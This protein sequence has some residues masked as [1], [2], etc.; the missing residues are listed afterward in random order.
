MSTSSNRSSTKR[1][2]VMSSIFEAIG[3][4]P[5]VRLN[6]IPKEEGVECEILA[7]C[8]FMNPGGSIKDRIS[9]EMINVAEAEGL[10]TPG[11]TIVEA[12]SGNTGIGLAL[13]SAVKGYKTIITIPDRMSNEKVSTLK[14]LGS[15]VIRTPSEAKTFDEASYYMLAKRLQKETPNAHILDQYGNP[16]NPSVHERTTGQEIFDQTEGNLDFVFAGAGTGGTITGVARRLK[17]L[18]PHIKVVGVDPMGSTLALPE[19]LNLPKKGLQ[20]E[21][22]GKDYVPKNLDRSLI[23]AWVKTDDPD[24]LRL[25]RALIAKEG[26]LC[27]SS[28]GAALEGCLKF[29]KENNLHTDPSIRCVIILP[30]SIRNYLSKFCSDEYMVK[31]GFM[32][33]SVLSSEDH[34]LHGKTIGDL[35]LQPISFFDDRLPVTECKKLFAKGEVAV[36]LTT[37]GKL[38]GIITRDSIMNWLTKKTLNFSA[39]ANAI[40]KEAIVV[41]YETDLSSIDSLLR[42]DDAVYVQRKD[43]D[44]KLLAIYAVTKSDLIKLLAQDV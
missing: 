10:L 31:K 16:A 12:S 25:A 37:E 14:S 32:Q 6:R 38:R 28:S 22:I 29:L 2:G 1:D 42:C 17:S 15:A 9:L 20:V 41:D 33:A 4:T 18:N 35:H 24:S 40:S 44:G 5:L 19:S 43:K 23:D 39:S 13:V 11:A 7:K 36:P 21:G 30:D 3:N 26:L 27:G 34:P 8:E